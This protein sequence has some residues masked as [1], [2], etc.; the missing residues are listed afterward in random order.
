MRSVEFQTQVKHGNRKVTFPCL[1]GLLITLSAFR[2]RIPELLEII[3]YIL[4]SRFTQDAL[5]KKISVRRKGDNNDHPTPVDFKSRVRMLMAEHLMSTCNSTNC[6]PD[7]DT[8]LIPLQ[9]LTG[10]SEAEN[11]I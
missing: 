3:P 2:Q 11:C 4:M 5:G 8:V 9:V 10:N 1:E 7:K 6:E